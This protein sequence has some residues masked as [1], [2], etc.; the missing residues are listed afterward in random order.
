MSTFMR[1]AIEY[2]AFYVGETT[3]GTTILHPSVF[4]TEKRHYELL[5]GERWR[6][7]RGWYAR[8]SAPG[9]TDCTD[10]SGPYASE[11]EAHE[12]LSDM[13]GDDPFEADI[14]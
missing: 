1:H 6:K 2:D 12:A 14:E 13:F 3:E 4:E 11:R 8:L 7:R 10:W 5:R 9:Y